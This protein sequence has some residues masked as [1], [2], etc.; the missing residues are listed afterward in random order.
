VAVYFISDGNHVKIGYTDGVPE[1]RLR[2]LQTG[3]P[4]PLQIM[5]VDTR[6]TVETERQ[7]HQRF[8]GYRVNG[9]WFRLVPQIQKYI[10]SM[11]TTKTKTRKAKTVSSQLHEGWNELTADHIKA[12]PNVSEKGR[13]A[14]FDWYDELY[15]NSLK[16]SGLVM[17]S[18]DPKNHVKTLEGC[19][20]YHDDMVHYIKAIPSYMDDSNTFFIKEKGNFYFEHRP[21]TRSLA[22]KL[23]DIIGKVFGVKGD[24]LVHA[25]STEMYRVYRRW[26]NFRYYNDRYWA[27]YCE[28]VE[29]V[30]GKEFVDQEQD[31]FWCYLDSVIKWAWIDGDMA[32]T[33]MSV[34]ANKREWVNALLD[35]GAYSVKHKVENAVGFYCSMG[36]AISGFYDWC[37]EWGHTP[38]Y[39]PKGN[40]IR[41]AP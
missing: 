27:K 13:K 25:Y 33:R 21:D 24:K 20:D 17:V 40:L 36:D 4:T 2:Q 23:T 32:L 37:S 9:E 18:G 35:V 29:K 22:G 28:Y 1:D 26:M 34:E 6:G 30:H 15:R 14:C 39:D 10:V 11:P 8:A 41:I 31:A 12:L 19:K 38:E 5:A 16:P 3:N 7:L